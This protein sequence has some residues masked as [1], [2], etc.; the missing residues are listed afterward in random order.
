VRRFIAEA[1]ISLCQQ[2]QMLT[3]RWAARH[4]SDTYTLRHTH[5]PSL[6]LRRSRLSVQWLDAGSGVMHEEMWC[7]DPW[8]V[9]GIE[10]YQLWVSAQRRCRA[11]S[12]CS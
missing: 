6:R 9:S 7:T 3:R 2:K 5:T 11:C 10:I 8:K 12:L 4:H 1:P